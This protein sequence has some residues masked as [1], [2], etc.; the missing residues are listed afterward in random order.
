MLIISVEVLAKIASGV[1]E[2]L[3]LAYGF[4]SYPGSTPGKHLMGLR[5]ISCVDVQPVVGALN[6]VTVTSLPYISLKRCVCFF[7]SFNM[8]LI[9]FSALVRSLLKNLVT[10][11][12]FPVNAFFYTFQYNRSIYDLAAKTIVVTRHE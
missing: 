3:C 2:A 10:N 4:A 9:Y 8:H 11:F 1:L 5:V 12:L 7:Y 6:Q